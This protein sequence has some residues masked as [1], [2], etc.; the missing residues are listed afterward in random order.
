MKMKLKKIMC[1][2]LVYVIMISIA[3]CNKGE[4]RKSVI[5][6]FTADFEADY[7]GMTVRGEVVAGFSGFTKI[8]I[9]YPETA[10][11]LSVAYKNGEVELG[12]KSLLS[13]A[14][15][16]YLPQ[17]SLPEIMYSIVKSLSVVTE[18]LSYNEENITTY[19]TS[20]VQGKCVLKVDEYG[21]LTQA[22]IKEE[23]V[24]I[25]FFNHITS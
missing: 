7:K 8:N 19:T 20:L 18:D 25:N 5:N 12:M 21:F 1:L 17:E 23:D 16:A 4:E 3:G 24:V 14:D 22:Q 2:I 10:E 13:T 9:S 15:E 6:Q 11:G